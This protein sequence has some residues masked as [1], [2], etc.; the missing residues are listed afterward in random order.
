MRRLS[1]R[2]LAALLA[3]ALFEPAPLKAAVVVSSG[4][5]SISHDESAGTW[6]LSAGGTSLKLMLDPGR[7]FSLAGLTTASGVPLAAAA[8]DTL[9]NLDG[10]SLAFGNRAAG[11]RLLNVTTDSSGDRLQLN[12]TFELPT[13]HLQMTRHYA[14]V[15]GSPVF[16]A[17]TTPEL[18]RRWWG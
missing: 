17:W 9:I 8:P 4:D 10:R 2:V 7:D 18:V 16:E 3:A 13:A 1:T 15:N 11:F 14:I 12:A 5:A 6:T